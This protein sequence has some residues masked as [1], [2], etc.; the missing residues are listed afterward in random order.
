MAILLMAGLNIGLLLAPA[1]LMLLGMPAPPDVLD[2][3]RHPDVMRDGA[4]V[5]IAIASAF[6]AGLTRPSMLPRLWTGAATLLGIEAASIG[7]AT[8]VLEGLAPLIG[9][10]LLALWAFSRSRLVSIDEADPTPACHGVH[11]IHS[12]QTAGQ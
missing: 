1:F 10:T 8:S 7:A 12:R 4:V 6:A 9:S 11:P 5:H 3:R 2:P